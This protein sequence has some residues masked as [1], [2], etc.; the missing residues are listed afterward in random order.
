MH[1]KSIVFMNQYYKGNY[2]LVLNDSSQNLEFSSQ[3]QLVSNTTQ[4]LKKR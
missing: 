4:E 3:K 1:M 2:T